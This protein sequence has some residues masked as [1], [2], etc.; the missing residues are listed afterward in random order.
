MEKFQFDGII[1][2]NVVR[3]VDFESHCVRLWSDVRDVG[4]PV[5]AKDFGVIRKSGP[6]CCDAE[7]YQTHGRNS[8]RFYCIYDNGH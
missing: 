3:N 5:H 7:Y 1:Y 8:W 2:I 6:Y 4:N